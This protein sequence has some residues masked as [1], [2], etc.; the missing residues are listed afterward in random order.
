M[1]NAA[2]TLSITPKLSQFFRYDRIT[3][4]CVTPGNS[5]G[6]SVWRNTSYKTAQVCA[7][8]WAIPAGV[9]ILGSPA[10]PVTEGDT[11]TLPCLYREEDEH[12]STSDFTAVFYKDD[13][14]IGNVAKGEMI[15]ESVS[16]SDE[17]HYRCEHPSKGKSEQSWLAVR[18]RVQPTTPPPLLTLPN[19]IS[20]IL[21]FILYT[22][23]L[24][25]C[26]Y[27]YRKWAKG[28]PQLICSTQTIVAALGDDVILP[29]HV[30]PLVDL[31]K[32]SVD[33]WR[34]DI[35]PDPGDA[36]G[37][38][39]HRYRDNQDAEVMKM[40]SYS[41][42]TALI[43]G[44]LKHS[45]ISLRISSVKLS[46]GGRYR[47]VVH[48]LASDSDVELV[49]GPNETS[50]NLVVNRSYRNYVKTVTTETPLHPRNLQTPDLNNE[51]NV[52]VTSHD[53]IIQSVSISAV[54]LLVVLILAGVGV[55]Y[56]LKHKSSKTDLPKE[57]PAKLLPV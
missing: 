9:V 8:G 28:R 38:Y 10:L 22:I 19:M 6:W 49:V 24:I 29:C 50:L 11:V 21:L 46:D 7:Y 42:R 16:K 35:P 13:V 18:D 20:T 47:C 30:E 31:E 40:S 27:M 44:D 51:T 48:Q 41:G 52:E 3:L 4:K 15:L 26:M 36:G 45:N 37:M 2:A 33:W 53:Q 1:W 34:P 39:V 43:R 57:D 23:I 14:F 12:E 55:G 17:G 56:L 25:I 32:M 54:V 5:T